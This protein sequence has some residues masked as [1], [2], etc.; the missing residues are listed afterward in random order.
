MWIF[1][2]NHSNSLKIRHYRINKGA[3]HLTDLFKS[4]LRGEKCLKPIMI[5]R[6]SSTELLAYQYLLKL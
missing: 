6:I 5:M 1:I 4:M 3:I 2:F